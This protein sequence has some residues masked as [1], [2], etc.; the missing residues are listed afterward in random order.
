[1]IDEDLNDDA[2]ADAAVDANPSKPKTAKK[3]AA[4]KPKAAKTS[5]TEEEGVDSAK[6]AKKARKAKVA[7]AAPMARTQRG[8]TTIVHSD[9]AGLEAVQAFGTVIDALN[10][11][12]DVTVR[13][14][15][16]SGT[17]VLLSLVPKGNN[18]PQ[19][20]G[21]IVSIDPAD[22]SAWFEDEFLGPAEPIRIGR[23]GAA[24]LEAVRGGEG[25]LT[26]LG[27]NADWLSRAKE[28]AAAA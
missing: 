1:V 22:R 10:A 2:K 11:G 12:D 19:H 25:P 5:A 27:W 16:P 3:K 8:E 18:D 6:R 28:A 13:N 21:L 26:P 4:T 17:S 15:V 23:A 24:A 9:D 20:P 7:E 14:A